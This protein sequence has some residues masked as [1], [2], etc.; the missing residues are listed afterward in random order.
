MGRLKGTGPLG[1]VYSLRGMN[2][3]EHFNIRF[4]KKKMEKA[5]K[6]QVKIYGP[7]GFPNIPI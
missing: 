4:L 5:R 1:K 2:A 3:D 6:T 7:I